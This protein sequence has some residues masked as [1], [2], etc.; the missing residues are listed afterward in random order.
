MIFRVGDHLLF[1]ADRQI[2]HDDDIVQQHMHRYLE[3]RGDFPKR[4]KRRIDLTTF[5]LGNVAD[6]HAGQLRQI[7]DGHFLILSEFTYL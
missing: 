4:G 2:A 5:D 7:L 1:L 3:P 6:G